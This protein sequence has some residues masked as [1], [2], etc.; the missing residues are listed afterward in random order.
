MIKSI[1]LNK[2]VKGKTAQKEHGTYADAS[3]IGILYNADEFEEVIINELI[4]IFERDQKTIGR[5]G[6]VEK[7]EDPNSLDHFLFCKK[8]IS[9]TGAIK[10]ESIS[11]FANQ[12]FDFLL[13]L[14]VSENINYKYVLASSKAN[15]KVGLETE[16]YSGLLLLAVKPELE[17]MASAQ[18]LVKYLKMI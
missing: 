10:K 1:F 17:K 2:K 5:L 9:G 4:G 8:D 13:S 11:F 16:S 6:F 15:C 14:D 7:P 12:S 18:T 3:S